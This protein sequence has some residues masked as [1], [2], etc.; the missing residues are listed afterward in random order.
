[1]DKLISFVAMWIM[2][3]CTLLLRALLTCL[4]IW[5]DLN[6]FL[7]IFW[8]DLAAFLFVKLVRKDIWYYRSYQSYSMRVYDAF[9]SR[10]VCKVICD[11]T[12][13]FQLRHPQEV[14]LDE[15]RSDEMITLALGTKTTTRLYLHTRCTPSP[16]TAIILTHHPNPF[17]DSLR[18]S[19]MG[20]A[21]YTLNAVIGLVISF[22]STW[23]HDAEIGVS[24]WSEIMT[25]L[26][27]WLLSTMVFLCHINHQH[28]S[29]FYSTMTTLDWN[30]RRV[31]KLVGKI[32][33]IKGA[34]IHAILYLVQQ[35]PLL[36]QGVENEIQDF[37][38]ENWKRWEEDKADFFVPQIINSL[39]PNYTAKVPQ[40]DPS[41]FQKA[42]MRSRRESIRKANKLILET[43]RVDKSMEDYGRNVGRRISQYHNSQKNKGEN[44]AA[45]FS[46]IQESEQ[47]IDSTVQRR[48]TQ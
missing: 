23:L 33:G 6:A 35:N 4:L 29:T 5:V 9:T 11:F 46:K 20:G 7:L 21:G 30:E 16:T 3:T 44:M 36:L 13:V 24:Y 28:L 19:Q 42:S 41:S 32:E 22:L 37:F 48:M 12:G 15:E 34:D 14:R 8:I 17:R 27:I 45:S 10:I 39:P 47:E 2:N 38:A 31:L 25:L 43:L 1:M 40:R 26:G 18:S